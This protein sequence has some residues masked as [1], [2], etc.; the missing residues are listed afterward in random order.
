MDTIAIPAAQKLIQTAFEASN[1]SAQNAR[2]VALALVAAEVDGQAGHGFSRVASYAAQ[3]RSGK[4]DGHAQPVSRM[5]APAALGIDAA[6]GFAF[7]AM[8]LA[9]DQLPALAREFGIAAASITRSHHCGQLTAHV[10][11]L[12]RAGLVTL[13]FANTPKAMAPWGGNAPLFGTNPIAFSAP[14][15]PHPLVIDLSLSKVARGKVMAASKKG[16]PIPEGWALDAAGQPTTDAKAALAGSMIPA[17]DAK[18]AALALM[19]EVLAASLTGANHSFEASSFFDAAGTS[20]GVGQLLIAIDA[21]K[22]GGP[23]FAERLAT[24]ANAI[25]GQGNTRLP[26]SSRSAKRTAAMDNGIAI[27]AAMRAEIEGLAK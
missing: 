2:S 26:G 11:K 20:P 23:G 21:H 18:G 9:I 22:V 7:P 25:I 13:M 14:M 10:E 19:V 16:D 5:L 4:V 6:H 17:G 3:A 27:S 12:A 8:D 24:L 15:H 1:V